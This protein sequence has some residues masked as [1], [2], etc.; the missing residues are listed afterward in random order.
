MTKNWKERTIER[1]KEIVLDKELLDHTVSISEASR[2]NAGSEQGGYL[3]G[4]LRDETFYATNIIV[5]SYGTWH[6]LRLKDDLGK[7]RSFFIEADKSRAQYGTI[8]FHSHPGENL[9]HREYW[10]NKHDFYQNNEHF[11]STK[12]DVKRGIFGRRSLVEVLNEDNRD[13]SEEDIYNIPGNVQVLISPTFKPDIPTSH[14]Q[15]YQIQQDAEL[16]FIRQV[17]GKIPLRF[18]NTEDRA[19]DDI[20]R[21]NREIETTLMKKAQKWLKRVNKELQPKLVFDYITRVGYYLDVDELNSL[22]IPEALEL[23]NERRSEERRL[24]AL[25]LH[26]HLRK[27]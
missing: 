11:Q 24:D 17:T 27:Q 23:A 2:I 26:A 3:R 20:K 1:C 13:L 8:A 19:I 21:L 9:E 18:S 12:E 4:M 5:N 10:K 15:A 6:R 7:D 22:G 25:V 14:L 16:D